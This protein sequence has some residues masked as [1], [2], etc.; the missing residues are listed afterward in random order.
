MV[1][2][3]GPE[4]GFWWGELGQRSGGGRAEAGL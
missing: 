3:G 4:A 2:M 1:L